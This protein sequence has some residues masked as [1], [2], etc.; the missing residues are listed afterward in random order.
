MIYILCNQDHKGCQ[1]VLNTDV[2]CSSDFLPD[3]LF[4]TPSN[5]IFHAAKQRKV[6]TF[7]FSCFDTIS[8]QLREVSLPYYAPACREV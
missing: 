2:D 4:L 6:I 5:P 1:F 3:V 8:L 7:F